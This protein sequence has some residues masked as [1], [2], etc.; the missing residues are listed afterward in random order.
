MR[1]GAKSAALPRQY[2][3]FCTVPQRQPPAALVS[4]CVPRHPPTTAS[5][6]PQPRSDYSTTTHRTLAL[7]WCF[8]WLTRNWGAGVV[9]IA[10][11]NEANWLLEASASEKVGTR[12]S[13]P[14]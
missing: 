8:W 7:A 14:L 10:S 11:T 2:A 9:Q 12:P 13:G 3:L 5:P 4:P 1:K 6:F